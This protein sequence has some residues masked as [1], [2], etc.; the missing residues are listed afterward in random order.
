VAEALELGVGSWVELHPVLEAVVVVGAF[1]G[2]YLLV[3]R[4][5]GAGPE[6]AA[7]G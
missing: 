6:T 3:T 2:I 4:T 1:A 7:E 5:Q